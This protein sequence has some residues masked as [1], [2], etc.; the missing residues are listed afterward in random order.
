MMNFIEII[1][2]A[3]KSPVNIAI[4]LS[5][6]ILAI[7]DIKY[8][9]DLKSQIV[10][11]GVLGTFIGIFIGLQNFNPADMKH[12]IDGILLGLKTA[13]FTSIVGMGVALLLSI[14]E[15]I[16][17]KKEDEVTRQENLLITIS[18]QLDVLEDINSNTKDNKVLLELKDLHEA[19]KDPTHF[20]EISDKLNILNT[21][22]TS[23]DSVNIM[24]ELQALQ[25][26]QNAT[27]NE[28]QN[29]ASVIEKFEENSSEQMN[30]LVSILDE[31]FE[32]INENLSIA[33][34][35]ISKGSNQEMLEG[36][37]ALI[38]NFSQKIDASFG[39]NFVKLNDSIIHL[40]TWQQNYK[41]HIES[42]EERLILS[43]NSIEKSKESL[44]LISSKNEEVIN[45]YKSLSEM[46]AKS[47]TQIETLNNELQTYSHLSNDAST[48]FSNIQ[49][50]LNTTN[51]AFQNLTQNIINSHIQQ[52]ESFEQIPETLKYTLQKVNMAVN[53]LTKKMQESSTTEGLEDERR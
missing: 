14:R 23:E 33:I 22:S 3:F 1:I 27:K 4:V 38:Q 6:V 18:Q 31:N 50:N 7:V 9:K 39:D 47:E 40:I 32:T 41:S 10:S 20:S 2:E 19:V 15:N 29:I 8:K 30:A 36:L 13:F 16:L 46:I 49:N 21:L 17:Y 44:K 48:M 42:L 52:K 37:E 25:T 51:K 28:S 12:S 35:E 26:I 45:V 34:Q 11:L 53:L 43:T 24:Q 5:I